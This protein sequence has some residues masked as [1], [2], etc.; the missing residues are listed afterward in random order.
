MSV[1]Y[2]I[3]YAVGK[4]RNAWELLSRGN[5]MSFYSNFRTVLCSNFVDYYTKFMIV[6]FM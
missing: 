3:E 1:F 5:L 4:L 6:I 2:S